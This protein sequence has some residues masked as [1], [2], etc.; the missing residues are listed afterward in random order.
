MND[1]VDLAA[2][3]RPKK[4][5]LAYTPTFESISG[6]LEK[7]CRMPQLGI[8]LIVGAPGV[9]K[10][11]ALRAH[12]NSRL[13]ILCTMSKTAGSLR[14]GLAELCQA[15][16]PETLPLRADQ[17]RDR[18]W[19]HL[20]FLRDRRLDGGDVLV[21]IDEAQFMG[22]DMLHMIRSLWDRVTIRAEPCIPLVL[23]GNP[24][25][26]TRLTKKG[27]E[28]IHSRLGLTLHLKAPEPGDVAEICRLHRVAGARAVERLERLA[29]VGG[30]RTVVRII[31]LAR[32]GVGAAGP[33]G[34]SDIEAAAEMLSLPFR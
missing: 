2:R 7:T 19:Q 34:P 4:E 14:Y 24:S 27:F 9:G 6:L 20:Q 8:G 12:A 22:D 25:V 13:R 16:S 3:R 15:F 29:A 11:T 5:G 1:V 30:L 21:M 23:A 31:A 28:Q 10:T 18:L 26:R 33:I 32:D 17:L